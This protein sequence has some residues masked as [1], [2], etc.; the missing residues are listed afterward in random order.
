[1]RS[2]VRSHKLKF[3]V[4]HWD[5]FDNETTLLDEFD[6]KLG[7]LDFV[8]EKYRDRIS[9]SGADVVEIVDERGNVVEKF[10]VK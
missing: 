10:P 6:T 1:M 5:T 2:V 9:I 3:G 8:N 7:A 4:Y